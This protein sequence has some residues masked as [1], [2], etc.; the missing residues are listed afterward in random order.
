MYL[1]SLKILGAEHPQLRPVKEPQILQLRSLR[2]RDDKVRRAGCF[3]MT[4]WQERLARSTLSQRRR[5][6][7]AP[8]VPT[9]T[10]E[11]QILRSNAHLYAF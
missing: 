1:E 7:G 6:D 10:K 5:K 8:K 4:E 11:V 3:G 9:A 2:A